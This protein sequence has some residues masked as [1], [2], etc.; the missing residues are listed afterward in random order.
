VSTVWRPT[1]PPRKWR[2]AG[3]LTPEPAIDQLHTPAEATGDGFGEVCGVS[4]FTACSSSS[5]GLPQ[6]ERVAARDVVQGDGELHECAH[7]LRWSSRTV[8]FVIV[9]S[10]QLDR[11]SPASEALDE[12]GVHVDRRGTWR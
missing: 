8:P 1:S 10:R 4:T 7:G 6:E 5:A 12:L 3:S 11:G 9:E 2:D